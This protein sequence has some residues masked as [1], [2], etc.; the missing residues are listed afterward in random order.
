LAA[1]L[2]LAVSLPVGASFAEGDPSTDAVGGD[3]AVGDPTVAVSNVEVLRTGE[4]EYVITL[5]LSGDMGWAE[6]LD[7][8]ICDSDRG[9][10]ARFL[11]LGHHELGPFAVGG[12]TELELSLWPWTSDPDH[13]GYEVWSGVFPIPAW[14]PQTGSADIISFSINGVPGLVYGESILVFLAPG[15]DVTSVEPTITTSPGATVTPTGPQNFTRTVEYI[16][17]GADGTT[18]K[19]YHV[20]VVGDV[21]EFGEWTGSGS[22]FTMLGFEA[23]SF[24]RLILNGQTVDPGNYVVEG[25]LGGCEIELT[26]A[27]LKSLPNGSY[28]FTVESLNGSLEVPLVVNVSQTDATPSS[29]ASSGAA[30]P[31]L[32]NTGI[33]DVTWPV[34]IGG[35]LLV[36]AGIACVR[37]RQVLTRT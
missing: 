18:T 6:T 27:F 21:A 31:K 13:E 29:S 20:S 24:V 16:V 37:R 34:G 23:A 28:V 5:D 36:V 25:V 26:E 30:K 3:A 11:E 15:A 9:C 8:Y 12:V 19:T 14:E 4:D 33:G 22:V 17:T 1:A 10:F 35:L 7:L 2:A 32:P